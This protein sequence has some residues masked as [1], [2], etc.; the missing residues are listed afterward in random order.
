MNPE[1]D[2]AALVD[3]LGTAIPG[4]TVPIL[5]VVVCS[6]V[7]MYR[8]EWLQDLLP[9]SWRWDNWP[10]FQKWAVSF[11][12][13]M[14]C[15]ALTN[16][17]AGKSWPVSITLG[18]GVGFGAMGLRESWKAGQSTLPPAPFVLPSDETRY[19]DRIAPME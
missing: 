15:G 8:R 2:F 9:Q 12:L 5:S 13:G 19:I 14:T 6:L 3:G 7:A 4:G 1:A 17:A 10:R 11:G 18:A 16:L